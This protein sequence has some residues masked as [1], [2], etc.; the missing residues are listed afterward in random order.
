MFS[1]G[2]RFLLC[3]W[4]VQRPETGGAIAPIAL[5]EL[6]SWALVS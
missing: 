5:E 3:T 4:W 1:G 6:S 2:S